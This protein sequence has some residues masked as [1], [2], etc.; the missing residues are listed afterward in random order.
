MIVRPVL[1]KDLEEIEGFD[2]SFSTDCVWQMDH[3]IADEEVSTTFRAIRLPRAIMVETKRDNDWLA[4][5]QNSDLLLA[6][7]EDR[8]FSGY[9]RLE[10]DRRRNW[11]KLIHLAVIRKKRRRGYG[12]A[13]IEEAKRWS[14]ARR[15]RGL[16]AETETR[17]YPAISFF[18]KSGFSF[19]GFN[20]SGFPHREIDVYFVCSLG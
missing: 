2:T 4:H 14:K 10:I 9:L 16:V 12:T 20:E 18:Q 8:V 5:W 7:E 13:L 3:R 19:C 6:V 17:N 1:T 11:G 15:V